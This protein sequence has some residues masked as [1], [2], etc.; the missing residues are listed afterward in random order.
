MSV[1]GVGGRSQLAVQN[2]VEMR[3]QLDDLQRQ[4][5]TG[6]KSTTFA[7]LG[8]DRGL[9]VGLRAQ[10]SGIQGFSDTITMLGVRMNLA[11]TALGR[12]GEIRTDAKAS[13]QQ[14]ADVKT[15]GQS[16]AQEAA[17]GQLDELL[18]LL[19][20]QVGDRYMF[21]GRA[22]D[23]AA[24]E[25]TDH[26]LDGDGARAGLTQV[27]SERAQADLGANGLGRLAVSATAG[28]MKVA[29][30]AIGSPFGFKLASASGNLSG[31]TVSGPSGA[32][33]A[34][35]V[36]F[37]A[38]PAAG[39][40]I[41]FTLNLPDGTQQSVKLTAT[42]ATPPGDGE[43]TI[44]ADPT[45]TAANLQAS[46]STALGGVAKT[47]L[48]AASAVAASNDFFN[49]DVGNPPRRVNGPPFDT[50]T[51]LMAGT[52]ANTVVWY[53]GEMGSDPARSTATAQVDSALNVSYGMRATEEGIRS[54]VQNIAAFAATSFDPNDAST[55]ARYSELTS[56]LAPALGS[57]PGVQRVED[58]SM[59]IASAQATANAAKTRH[60]QTNSVLSGLLDNVEGVPP[61]QVATQILAMQTRLQASLQTTAMLYQ[62]NL[63]NYL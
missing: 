34:V 41:T 50:A 44:G 58:I 23:K 17:R 30:D 35:S 40:S 56:R 57:P 42:T 29:E 20:T 12:I 5:G 6:K 43:F 10:L 2:L 62:L 63:T 45:A 61:E 48:A 18:S 51:G 19:N 21:S 32:P 11:Q 54:V 15:N 7:G 37:T 31:A 55:K 53:T 16:T 8:V 59:D 9:A 3:K 52:P 25:S 4:L 49:I 27:I 24:V 47:S 14:T 22:L 33:P 26:I 60:Q 36:A 1:N 46:L 13:M 28:T 39:E 38:N